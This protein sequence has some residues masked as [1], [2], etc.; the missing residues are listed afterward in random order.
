VIYFQQ[1]AANEEAT[2]PTRFSFQ[3]YSARNHPPFENVLKKLADYGYA[4]VEG[5]VGV[6]GEPEKLRAEMNRLGLTMPTG[7]FSVEMLEKEKKKVLKTA[8][9]LGM[10]KLVCP[11][12]LPDKRPKTAKGWKDFGKRLEAISRSYRAEGYSV[13][14]HN[15]DFEFM[16]LR[17][18]S[19]PHELIFSAAPTLDWE[20][21]VAWIVRGK[22]N[23]LKWIKA[24][25]GTITIAHVKDIAPKGQC[26]DEDGWA[27][28]GHGVIKWKAVMDALKQT[29]CMHYVM[30]H[31]KPSDVERFARRSL[32]AAKK[33]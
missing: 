32:A 11:Y 8:S 25:A 12:L 16:P 10:N 22:S 9:M 24:Y 23:P 28:V 1:L 7:H 21:D 6:Y 29:R 3:L 18:G 27:D 15:H 20:I 14:W 13:A 31:D 26:V 19:T 4:E 2:M 17:D 30:E 5:F 33:Y